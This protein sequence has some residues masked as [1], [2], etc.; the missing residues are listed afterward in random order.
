MDENARRAQNQKAEDL[1][2]GRRHVQL[3]RRVADHS[4]AGAGIDK[5]AQVHLPQRNKKSRIDRQQEHEIEP[6]GADQVRKL[7][8]I[9]QK[10]RLEDLLNELA[11]PDQHHHF[12]FGPGRNVIGVQVDHADKAQLQRE[13]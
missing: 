8:A 9:G 10:K 12:P 6:A 11:G 2:G 5:P 7:R 4:Q 13:P 1:G 3:P